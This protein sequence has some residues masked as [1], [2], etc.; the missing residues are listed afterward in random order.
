MVVMKI[1]LKFQMVL[2]KICFFMLKNH[3]A[4]IY[5]GCQKYNFLWCNV[6]HALPVPF[7]HLITVPSTEDKWYISVL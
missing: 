6:S 3:N 1:R 2:Q 7:G 4:N 5:I